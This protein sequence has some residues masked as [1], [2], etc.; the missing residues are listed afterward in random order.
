MDIIRKYILPNST[1]VHSD[2]LQSFNCVMWNHHNFY[3]FRLFMCY[4]IKV[5]IFYINH[6][7]INIFYNLNLKGFEPL[8]S[9]SPRGWPDGAVLCPRGRI[10]QSYV[11]IN[12]QTRNGAGVWMTSCPEEMVPRI[13]G[14]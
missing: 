6:F 10:P 5:M 11:I 9:L 8:E 1:A 2:N 14:F 7:S 4:I 12:P 13:R 3:T